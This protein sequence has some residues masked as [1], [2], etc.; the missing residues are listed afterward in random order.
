MMVNA[1]YSHLEYGRRRL[2]QILIAVQVVM[3]TGLACVAGTI[4]ILIARGLGWPGIPWI[5]WF[6][7][8]GL[9]GLAGFI[10]GWRHRLDLKAVARWLDEHQDNAELFS[11]ALV[12]L[13]RNCA[14]TFDMCIIEQAE[15][16][17]GKKSQIHWPLRYLV[18]KTTITGGVLLGTV[19]IITLWKPSISWPIPQLI[20]DGPRAY[21]TADSIAVSSISRQARNRLASPSPRELAQQLFPRNSKLVAEFEEALARGEI[22]QLTELMKQAR[23]DFDAKILNNDFPSDQKQLLDEQQ[24][25]QQA[26]AIINNLNDPNQGQYWRQRDDSDSRPMKQIHSQTG[27]V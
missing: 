26:Q 20:V 14:E 15:A 16:V 17:A 23:L 12:C 10:K 1:F 8:L 21:A 22:Q 25:L 5:I 2:N 9:G 19:L 7:F 11:A 4:V 24:H 3:M 27:T 18:Q 13:E 6:I